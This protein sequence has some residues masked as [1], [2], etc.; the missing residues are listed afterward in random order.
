[1]FPFSTHGI[2]NTSLALKTSREVALTTFYG[3]RTHATDVVILLS[4]QI[5]QSD[6]YS[7]VTYE[8]ILMHDRKIQ[9]FAI[10]LGQEADRSRYDIIGSLPVNK[11]VLDVVDYHNIDDMVH[12]VADTLCS[13]ICKWPHSL[14]QLSIF[15]LKFYIRKWRYDWGKC[16]VSEED[17]VCEWI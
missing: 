3:G 13:D 7:D 11:H 16:G 10:V 2:R 14:C 1:M 8:A 5:G 6:R 9:T 4:N 15:L 12:D 17:I